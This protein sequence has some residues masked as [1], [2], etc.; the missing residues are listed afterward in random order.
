M[1]ISKRFGPSVPS[2][3]FVLLLGLM[4]SI[5][6]AGGASRADA[7]GQVIVRITSWVCLIILLLFRTPHPFRRAGWAF[8]L[9]LAALILTL[10]QLV[11]LPPALWQ[12]L[13][14]RDLLAEAAAISKMPQPWRPWTL[15]PTATLNAASSLI[16]PLTTFLL[17]SALD[18]SGR[19][20][21]LGL[22]L[23]VVVASM[24]SGLLQSVGV[25][26]YNPL[27][28]ES[29]G[30]VSGPFANRNHFALFLAL[31]CMLA[32]AWAFIDGPKPRWRALLALGF[33]LL[34]LLE[35]LISGSR[36]GTLIAAL[37]VAIAFLL[38]WPGLKNLFANSPRWLSAA[39][40]AGTAS[41]I[42]LFVT[43]S[44]VADRAVSINRAF[45]LDTGQDMR[46]RG[47]PTVLAMIREYFPWGSGLGGFDTVF[48]IHEP[49][50][51]LK[52]TYFNHAHND[53]LEIVLDAGVPGLLL[54]LSMGAWWAWASIKAWT[55]T[56]GSEYMLARVGSGMLLLIF[57]ASIFDYPARTPIIMATIAI[58]AVWLSEA[59]RESRS[60][61]LPDRDQHL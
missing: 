36:A 53:I 13:P 14:G 9:L 16:V 25:Y 60:S 40:M 29:V 37:S 58:A 3:A 32:P 49:L 5:W 47:L 28:N 20:Y 45:A 4:A 43:L 2:L 50:N 56:S 42:V 15:S 26:F 1:K 19:K 6:I 33:V 11:P 39:V 41:A 55:A 7:F 35:I 31:G 23:C 44:I 22:L 30:F 34:F 54:M 17:M 24:L 48:R 51:L 10:V 46:G 18:A 61:A 52:P 57:I 38:I 21:A 59:L 12:L 27:I 8:A